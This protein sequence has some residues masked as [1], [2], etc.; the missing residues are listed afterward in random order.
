MNERDLIRHLAHVAHRYAEIVVE[1]AERHPHLGPLLGPFPPPRGRRIPGAS[2]EAWEEALWGLLVEAIADRLV[3]GWDRYGAPSAARDPEGEGYVASAEGPGEP[4]VVRASTKREA[5]REARKAW[6]RR[7]LR[8]GW[9]RAL[10]ALSPA[11]LGLPDPR[12]VE[13][14]AGKAPFL[15]GT[16]GMAGP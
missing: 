11:P 3:D 16:A 14:G 13:R 8:V 2:P 10:G 1:G 9:A 12:G 5:Y 6:V 4:I 15:G 7:L